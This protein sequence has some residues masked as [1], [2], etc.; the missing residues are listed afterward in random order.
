MGRKLK[1][2]VQIKA[3]SVFAVAVLGLV[4]TLGYMQRHVTPSSPTQEQAS[5]TR[6]SKQQVLSRRRSAIGTGALADT[7]VQ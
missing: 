1:N 2:K 5:H 4:V 6:L 3:Y 7:T